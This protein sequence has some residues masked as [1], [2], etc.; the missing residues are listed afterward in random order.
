MRFNAVRCGAIFQPFFKTHAPDV[1]QQI[2]FREF[3]NAVRSVQFSVV[4]MAVVASWTIARTR[5]V[6]SPRVKRTF[7]T[8]WKKRVGVSYQGKKERK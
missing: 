2:I 4:R 7:I 5:I 1:E 6:L 3:L 8:V